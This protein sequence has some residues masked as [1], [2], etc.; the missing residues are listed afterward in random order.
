MKH[1]NLIEIIT[2]NTTGNRQELLLDLVTKSKE[3]FEAAPASGAVRRHHAYDGGLI[4][5]ICEIAEWTLAMAGATH[6]TLGVAGAPTP[7]EIVT[8]AILHDLNKIGDGEGNPHYIPNVSE[9]TGKR[10]V[11]EPFSTNKG[12]HKPASNVPEIS[13][14]IK[15]A[16]LSCGELSLTTLSAL[17]GVLL[18]DLNESEINAIRFHDGGYGK[19]KYAAGY[20]GKEDRLVILIHAADMLSSRKRNWAVDTTYAAE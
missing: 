14:I 7:Q 5:H 2:N 19:A 6:A 10:S 3:R 4:D 12:A 8:V 16:E 18:S 17:S 15:Y 1:E 20:Q 11:A 9:K 13:T